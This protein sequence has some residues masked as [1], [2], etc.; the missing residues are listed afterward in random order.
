M[1]SILGSAGVN[2][3]REKIERALTAKGITAVEKYPQF[4][5]FA[6]SIGDETWHAA[7]A[8]VEGA[9]E[10]ILERVKNPLVVAVVRPLLASFGAAGRAMAGAEVRQAAIDAV[11]GKPSA[12]LGVQSNPFYRT[13]HLAGLVH[14]PGRDPAVPS[15][16][17]QLYYQS[18]AQ[19]R[20]DH[21]D[22]KKSGGK[23]APATEIKGAVYE[24]DYCTLEDAEAMHL[25]P[26]ACLLEGTLPKTT[27]AAATT[28]F[29]KL[30][31]TQRL[32]LMRVLEL[33]DRT[34]SLKDDARV[35]NLETMDPERIKTALTEG[36]DT[37]D[38][39]SQDSI[40]KLLAL[41]EKP[42]TASVVGDLTNEAIQAIKRRDFSAFWAAVRAGDTAAIGL[43]AF[44]AV[45]AVITTW[46]AV[47]F[48][49]QGWWDGRSK[50]W[51]LGSLIL[52]AVTL[53]LPLTDDL[54]NAVATVARA[55]GRLVGIDPKP[56]DPERFRQ[57]GRRIA[58]LVL[59]IGAAGAGII[60]A[61]LP[62]QA[63]GVLLILIMLMIAMLMVGRLF[64]LKDE[65]D[66]TGKATYK[67]LGWSILIIIVFYFPIGWR[68]SIPWQTLHAYQEGNAQRAETPNPRIREV[69]RI[70][71]LFGEAAVRRK[72]V[73]IGDDE[74]TIV[75]TAGSILDLPCFTT[76]YTPYTST[77]ANTQGVAL[78]TYQWK[79]GVLAQVSDWWAE[80]CYQDDADPSETKK[81]G[82]DN[83]VTKG[84]DPS[85]PAVADDGKYLGLLT[86]WQAAIMLTAGMIILFRVSAAQEGRGRMVAPIKGVTFGGACVCFILA[87][88]VCFDACNSGEQDG[89]KQASA[90]RDDSHQAS[91]PPSNPSASGTSVHAQS[92][93][94][95]R[96]KQRR[97][98]CAKTYGAAREAC[99]EG[100]LAAHAQ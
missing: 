10:A 41:C 90:G 37:N 18:H 45:L 42:T 83:T 60:E 25:Q 68:A 20:V 65:I 13:P 88:L 91:A 94:V 3:F 8:G 80:R 78:V 12:V 92:A 84:L 40:V 53:F 93:K 38:Q 27:T 55:A 67:S 16:I 32:R 29:G 49:Y 61:G 79:V 51:I 63:R 17:C 44:V 62:A 82:A 50:Q 100:V 14:R 34:P 74:I 47:A 43:I 4:A 57:H 96:P 31:P 98:V 35:R 56:G 39:P 87:M 11:S 46:G 6:T 21:P 36:F 85:K 73:K 2:I 58:G 19:W 97:D 95:E 66:R 7:G 54:F 77:S 59:I 76:K 71:D 86:P 24:G 26:C 9:L 81:E 33:I 23:G 99:L 64:G 15:A 72:T 75:A 1:A 48:G 28:L 70:G 89:G 5:A 52:W 22:Q 30:D 69:H